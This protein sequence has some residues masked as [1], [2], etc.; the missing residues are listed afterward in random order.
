MIKKI[1]K[2]SIYLLLSPVV[3]FICLI[4]PIKF[5][6]FCEIFS[7][8]FGEFIS[9]VEGFFYNKD[10]YKELSDS[11]IIFFYGPSISNHQIKI[12]S[13]FT[14]L[15][16]KKIQTKKPQTEYLDYTKL[17]TE[18]PEEKLISTKNLI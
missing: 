9:Q 15:D 18:L 11:K 3:Y 7:G 12:M 16:L 6:R 4:K 1:I 5:I 2:F 10:K 8:R 14:T 13:E 17:Q